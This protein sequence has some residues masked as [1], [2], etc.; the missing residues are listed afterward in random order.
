MQ[1]AKYKHLKSGTDV[2]GIAVG[3][4][5]PVTLTDG[6]VLDVTRAFAKWLKNKSGKSRLKIAVGNDSRIS[7]DR[8]VKCVKEG[9]TASGCNVVYTGLSSTPSMFILLKKSDFGCDGS[10]M[11]TASHLPYDRNGLKFFTP[12][13][14]LDGKDI[15]EILA[16]AESGNFENG[17]GVCENKSFMDGYSGILVD[18]IRRQTGKEKPLAGKKII[19]DAGNGAGGFFADKVLK[20]LGA[21]TE[22]SQ[23]LEPDGLFPNHA[24]NPEDKQAIKS[25]SDAVVKHGADLG[26][27]FDTDVDRAGAVDCDGGEINRNR[28][29]ALL[30]AMLL[31]DKAGVI[32]TDSVTS[33]GLTEFIESLG[34]KHLRYMRGYKN[35]IDKCNEVN[36]AGGYSPL[37]IE[38]SGHAAFL[39]NYMLDDGAY[40]VAKLLISLANAKAGEKLTSVISTLPE[41]VECDEIR[42]TFNE[43]SAD[44]KKEGAKLIEDLKAYALK[45]DGMRLAEENYEGARINFKKGEGDGWL[46]LR[47][48]V[49]DPVIPINFE[50]NSK[51]G[52]KLM[53]ETLL[54]FLEGYEFLNLE[55]LKNF[56]Y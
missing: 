37:A 31:K 45:S 6:A 51:G 34:G 40:V 50:S 23:F 9:L 30:S 19:V 47:Q 14:G 25:L 8:I 42:L 48:S 1:S 5:S 16:L 39:E 54:K 33:D 17:K 28:L 3:D 29:I 53:A 7:A 10:I 22:G 11:I 41:A 13:G 43:K 27:I 15:D 12:D 26:I 2:R 36:A 18:L 38:T 32:V 20:P 52:N 4:N 46:L 35:V 21:N 44:F 55:N 49:H 56:T 24:P